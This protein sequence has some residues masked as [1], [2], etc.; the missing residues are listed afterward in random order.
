MSRVLTQQ[1]RKE[2]EIWKTKEIYVRAG[3]I[4]LAIERIPITVEGL[5]LVLSARG[6]IKYKDIVSL[7]NID[8]C[9]FASF[10]FE[11]NMQSKIDA[12]MGFSKEQLAEIIRSGVTVNVENITIV[13]K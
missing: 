13:L 6:L 9:D 10:H 2:G 5:R 1:F 12:L 7:Q 11:C 8:V 4:D 3:E